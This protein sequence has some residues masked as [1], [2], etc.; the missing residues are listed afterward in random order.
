MKTKI[1]TNKPITVFFESIGAD[2]KVASIKCLLPAGADLDAAKQAVERS[3]DPD[4]MSIY[5]NVDDVRSVVNGLTT[6][7]AREVLDFAKQ[8]HDANIG[9]NWESLAA[10][11][12]TLEQYEKCRNGKPWKDCT[13]C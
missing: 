3:C 4:W 6:S 1:R 10:A 13:C 12:E 2:G 8:N 5:W 9:I 11:H 7:L